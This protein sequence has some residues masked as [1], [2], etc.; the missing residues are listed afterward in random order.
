LRK[1]YK[2]TVAKAERII[3]INMVGTWTILA[4]FHPPRSLCRMILEWMIPSS[5]G[6]RGLVMV[7]S[8]CPIPSTS[9][10]LIKCAGQP[11]III[12]RRETS[13]EYF[14]LYGSNIPI[15]KYYLHSGRLVANKDSDRRLP[16][17]KYVMRD[18]PGISYGTSTYV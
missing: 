8:Q 10:C 18:P 12:Q 7:G 3:L 15:S 6:L 14:T 11:A 16:S 5:C 17:V 13:D 9:L 1:C 4:H 2:F